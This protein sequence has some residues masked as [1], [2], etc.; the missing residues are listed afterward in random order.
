[1]IPAFAI[2][3]NPSAVVGALHTYSVKLQED[4]TAAGRDFTTQVQKLWGKLD[5]YTTN[6]NQESAEQLESSKFIL[7]KE[8]TDT[9][10]NTK[11][12]VRHLPT[13]VSPKPQKLVFSVS[14]VLTF[15]DKN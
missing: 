14:F 10:G 1:M 3:P 7:F 9:I 5:E 13:E 4:A 2:F 8:V 6:A 11:T 15:S 12:F